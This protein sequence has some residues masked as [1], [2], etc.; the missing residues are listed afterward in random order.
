MS[1]GLGPPH[2][3]GELFLEGP[4]DPDAQATVTDFIDYTEYLP[5]DLV[6]SLTLVRDLDKKY[7]DAAN[8]VH[9]LTKTYGQ[10]PHLPQE[11][12]PE[13]HALRVQI[14]EQLK[15]AINAREASFAE[16]SRLYDVVDRHFN[17][18]A[19]IKS[20][21]VA[22][23]ITTAREL[24]ID[25]PETKD[26]AAG[27]KVEKTEPP[28]RIT[29]RLDSARQKSRAA[30]RG[31]RGGRATAFDP[32]QVAPSVEGSDADAAIGLG[33][34]EGQKKG[35]KQKK[36]RRNP[37]TLQGAEGE[38]ITAERSTSR[39][40]AA[41][42]APPPDAKIG[43]EFLPWLR[44][45]DWE[46]ACL[47]KKMKKNNFWQPSEVMIHRELSELGRGWDN[48]RAAREKAESTGT[49]LIDCDDIMNNYVQGKL[50]RKSE[51]HGNMG[52]T[53]VEET[54]L[55]NRAKP[56][57]KPKTTSK[58]RKFEE[59]AALD[60]QE[61]D[62]EPLTSEAVS[63]TTNVKKLRLTKP[64]LISNESSIAETTPAKLSLSLGP[65]GS[66]KGTPGPSSAEPER[67]VTRSGRRPSASS[68][69]QP[70]ST[71]PTGLKST[72]HRSATAGSTEAGGRE[73]LHRK[74]MTPGKAAATDAGAIAPTVALGTTAASRRSKRPAPGPVT[75]GQD[76]G[77]AVSVG[78][79]KVKP[80]KKKKDQNPKDAQLPDGYRID[81]DGVVEE[82]DPNE[83]RY[84]ICGDVSFGTMICCEDNDCDREWFHLEC[85][86]L[87]EVPS[88][89]AKWYCPDC[90]KKLGKAAADGIVRS[91]GRR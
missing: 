43:S 40:L 55:I 81:E 26:G 1:G 52:T 17:R 50:T 9:K 4:S 24:A 53:G 28:T 75:A 11:T 5:S 22:L 15:R 70:V 44:L 14:S 6:R 87:T 10:L 19:S 85:V 72:R 78:R 27:A 76:G 33:V 38:H 84:C 64:A 48:Y 2:G 66:A 21:L 90:R 62:V 68:K 65:S 60:A 54:K 23:S 73:A 83:P 3:P 82:I 56:R 59:T 51:V 31:A 61:E 80:A 45:T 89:T 39:A 47:R 7:L 41:L 71:P 16:A 74:S 34:E 46:M 69:A 32:S 91:G 79:R 20:K 25:L 58:K 88:R 86:G 42:S 18:L 29:L 30:Q 77:S 67:P 63:G 8:A 49:E 12:R 36:A 57:T 35:A 13:P 37:R